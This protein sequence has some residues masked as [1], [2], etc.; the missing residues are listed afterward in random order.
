MK[1]LATPVYSAL[2]FPLSTHNVAP[3]MMEFC[4]APATSAIVGQHGDAELHVL[5]GRAKP[6][7]EPAEAMIIGHSP[8]VNFG[9]GLPS[10][11][12]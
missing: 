2:G 12:A 9:L 7:A 6:P 8:V 4:G 1:N 3:P 10:R 11:P 5:H